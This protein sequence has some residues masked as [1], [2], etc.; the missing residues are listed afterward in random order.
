MCIVQQAE[1]ALLVEFWR[2][3]CIAY[4]SA[5]LDQLFVQL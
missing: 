3:K 2:I 5:N 1:V 4:F